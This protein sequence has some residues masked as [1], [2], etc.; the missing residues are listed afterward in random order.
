MWRSSVVH[1][2]SVEREMIQIFQKI[3]NKGCRAWEVKRF[4][5]RR[6][7]LTLS[8]FN[9]FWCYLFCPLSFDKQWCQYLSWLCKYSPQ[10]ILKNYKQH[11][12]C[13]QSFGRATLA[14]V[15][16]NTSKD[17][18]VLTSA[19]KHFNWVSAQNFKHSKYCKCLNILTTGYLFIAQQLFK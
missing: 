11:K 5:F 7:R 3:S 10:A 19:A 14:G 12:A 6:C 2:A 1:S 15:L 4:S 16:K 18:N 9:N 17:A 13:M 8:G